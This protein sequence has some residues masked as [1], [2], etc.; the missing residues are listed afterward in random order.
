MRDIRLRVFDSAF[1]GVERVAPCVV[2]RRLWIFAHPRSVIFSDHTEETSEAF[3]NRPRDGVHHLR[4]LSDNRSVLLARH[5]LSDLFNL[6]R[7]LRLLTNL[8]LAQ[9]IPNESMIRH[10]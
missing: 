8:M 9:R 5:H 10:E 3:K 2:L 4:I 7:F 1:A 6:L